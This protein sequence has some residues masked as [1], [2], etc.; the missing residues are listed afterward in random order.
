MAT[1][2]Q[3]I[4]ATFV[5]PSAN[6]NRVIA[7]ERKSGRTTFVGRQLHGI[8][9]CTSVR[10]DPVNGGNGAVALITTES[11]S[12]ATPRRRMSAWSP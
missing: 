9:R 1:K 4:S 11:A 7:P 12:K 2:K 5:K 10:S 6:M 3:T 8:G